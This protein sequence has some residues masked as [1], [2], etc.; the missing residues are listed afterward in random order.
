M[1]SSKNWKVLHET[2]KK[3]HKKYKG[4]MIFPPNKMKTSWLSENIENKV[5][6]VNV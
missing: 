3:G 1:Q 4:H 2:N 6:K 5:I